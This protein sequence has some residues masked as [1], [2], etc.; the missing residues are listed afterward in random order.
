MSFRDCVGRAVDGGAMDRDRAERILREYDGVFEAFRDRMGHTQA[1]AEAARRVVDRAKIEAAESRRVKQLQA[2]ISRRNLERMEQHRTMSGKVSPGDYVQDFI[3]NSRGAGGSTLNG[4]KEAVRAS[5]RREM[6]EAIQAF[7]ANLVGQRRNKEMLDK[8]TREILGEATGDADAAGM[9]QAWKR[10]SE[11]ARK[12]F[13]AAGGHI[14]KLEDWGLPQSH[15]VRRVRGTPYE[16]WRDFILPRIDLEAMGRTHNDGVPFTPQTLEV[17]LKNA[18]DAIRTDG[19]SKRGP[20]AA[21]GSAMYNRKADHRFFK[22]KD[23]DAW[24]SYNEKFGSG[25]DPF[26]V[27]MAHLDSMS[28][29]IA[30]MEHLGPNPLN[31]FQFLKDAAQRK[32]ALTLD[33]DATTKVAGKLKQADDMFD[34]VSGASYVPKHEGA[35][36]TLS[37]VRQFLTSAQLGSATISSITDFNTQRINAGFLGM[38]QT[39][40]MK[41]MT[42][43]IT[44]AEFRADANRAGLIFQN[45]VD[46]GNAAAR[47]SMEDLHI[48]SAARLADFTIRASG[49][50]YLTELQRHS[51][52]LEFMSTMASKWRQSAHADL[53]PQIRGVM[54]DYGIGPVE[55]EVIRAAPTHRMGNGLEVVRAQEIEEGGFRDVADLYQEMIYS[56]T[57]FSVPST[58]VYSR[59]WVQGRGAPGSFAGEFARTVGQYKAFP[60]T[61]MMTQFARI[62]AM[63]SK[64]HSA[65]AA[66]YF[67]SFVIGSTVLG[68]LALQMKEIAK[69]KDP[70]DMTTPTF[71]A[72]A[73]TQGGGLGIMGDFFT[74]DVNRFGGG[75]AQ[76]LSGPTVGLASDLGK[77]TVGNVQQAISGD[78]MKL[79]REFTD[80]LR[81]YTPGGNLWYA[82][83]VYER[84]VL[85][86]LQSLLD[87]KANDS[88]K[89]RMK[90]ADKNGTQYY[91]RP[92]SHL[93][94]RGSRLPDFTNALGR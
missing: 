90:T 88:F 87:P 70:R 11:K 75:W 25:E 23:A 21:H 3:A 83:Q 45:A 64:G 47:Y 66:G 28:L 48:E 44:S 12:R 8:V 31:G 38:S 80:L 30:M 20:S 59:A 43:L 24:T 91:A 84:E 53:D 82:R 37:A 6:T 62:M 94:G 61:V 58:D 19:Y 13:N 41:Q 92:G 93:F 4:K 2:A 63:H 77:F 9:A 73:T 55:W 81:R 71:W 7:S 42:G 15:N 50:G 76:T 69:G 36:K 78:D 40:F 26:R 54:Q 34:L 86:Q 85:D 65:S 14:G 68:A 29:D 51:F 49:L 56:L 22:F 17:V 67:A 74:N 18:Y 32:A 60:I 57:E 79:G 46:M 10:V 52:G 33:P 35:A 1:Q 5:F 89:A 16:E 72:Q 39:G 27:M